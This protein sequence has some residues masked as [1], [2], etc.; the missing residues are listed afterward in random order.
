MARGNGFDDS[1]AG[2]RDFTVPTL[3]ELV[4]LVNQQRE[5]LLSN[6]SEADEL[7][8]ATIRRSLLLENGDTLPQ[9]YARGILLRTDLERERTEKIVHA[10]GT[11][12]AGTRD[13][14][15]LRDP[16]DPERTVC[17]LEV[18]DVDS[19]P[20][21]SFHEAHLSAGNRIPCPD[22]DRL[23]GKLPAAQ[24][25]WF[26]PAMSPETE[27]EVI[28]RAVDE[29]RNLLTEGEIGSDDLRALV[30]D[31][32][33]DPILNEVAERLHRQPAEFFFEEWLG[34]D[35]LAGPI[36]AAYGRDTLPP[37]PI[38]VLIEA[39]RAQCWL[40]FDWKQTPFSSCFFPTVIKESW[41]LALPAIQ[42]LAENYEDPD[43]NEDDT[44]ST[45][46]YLRKH[47]C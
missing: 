26:W 40:G 3:D 7:L 10:V 9:A 28:R 47:F 21:G 12:F 44:E 39:L 4:Y 41:P 23:G 33:V 2:P 13:A 8:E 37:P 31:L 29:L 24:E 1:T 45:R 17:G 5:R 25:P 16:D 19:A 32:D 14:L 42:E 11:D 46:S 36:A 22:C 35:G 38:E 43:G 18:S 6:Q 15:C 20:R 30:G 34:L 27:A